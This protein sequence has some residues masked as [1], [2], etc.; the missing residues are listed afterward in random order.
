LVTFQLPG[1]Q[2]RTQT[3]DKV[4][5]ATGSQSQ[6]GQ[7]FLQG[8]SPAELVPVRARLPNLPGE[9]KI[10]KKVPGRSQY[11]IGAAATGDPGIVGEDEKYASSENAAS[12]FALRNRDV[13]VADQL[14][15]EPVAAEPIDTSQV[16]KSERKLLG[17][18]GV[19][20]FFGDPYQPG[21]RVSIAIRPVPGEP[22]GESQFG[23]TSVSPTPSRRRPTAAKELLLKVQMADALDKFRFPGIDRLTITVS[24]SG[25][26]PTLT[27]SSLQLSQKDLQT[28]AL[29]LQTGGIAYG[30]GS[31]LYELR[32]VLG[33]GRPIRFEVDVRNSP[34]ITDPNWQGSIQ[35][36]SITL[37]R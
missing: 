29:A 32:A 36:G 15:Q 11:V 9:R 33:G 21:G 1:G 24:A 6:G 23:A 17:P 12:L 5:W 26:P 19:D 31:F 37:V 4:V 35:P 30:D 20:V 2:T 10:A 14:A 3:F 7:Q 25:T 28:F 22:A 34:N 13:A 8:G 27:L 16:G 18:E